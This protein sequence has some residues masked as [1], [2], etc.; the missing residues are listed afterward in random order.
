MFLL[1]KNYAK[2]L[3]AVRSTLLFALAR[4]PQRGVGSE[5][6]LSFTKNFFN[7]FRLRNLN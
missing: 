7:F 6:P 1:L 4:T 3:L 2:R 5:V